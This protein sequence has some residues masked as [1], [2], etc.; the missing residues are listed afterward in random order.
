MLHLP[1]QQPLLHLPVVP[2]AER[3]RTEDSIMM[4]VVLIFLNCTQYYVRNI[5]YVII[6]FVFSEILLSS[7]SHVDVVNISV[8]ATGTHFNEI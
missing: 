4:S 8:A 6:R 2:A 1:R 5:I 7:H 3:R